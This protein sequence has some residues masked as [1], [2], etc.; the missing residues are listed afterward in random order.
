MDKL[1]RR[2]FLKGTGIATGVAIIGASPLGAAAATEESPQLV[3]GTS[4]LPKEPLV[5][6][7]SDAKKHVVTVLVGTDE[8][9][10]RD[11]ALVK[12]LLKV[13]R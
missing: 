12:R 8:F 1:S 4:P 2:S 5:A 7:V 11:P 6:Y 13:V 9:T 10:F 3:K